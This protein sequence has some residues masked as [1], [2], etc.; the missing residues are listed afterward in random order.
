MAFKKGTSGNKSGRKKGTPN[1]VTKLQR[2]FIQSLLD[3]QQAKIKY[4]LGRLHGKDYLGTV[5]GLMEFVMPKLQRTELVEVED[6][7]LPQIFLSLPPGM[8]ISLPSDIEGDEE[9]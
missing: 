5:T 3:A 4:E 7:P 8:D 6:K 2:E 1:K 9:Q